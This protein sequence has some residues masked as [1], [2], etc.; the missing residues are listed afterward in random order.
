[1]YLK[2]LITGAFHFKTF[3][4]QKHMYVNSKSFKFQLKFDVK[5]IKIWRSK[6]C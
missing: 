1:M 5:V 3:I 4:T 6:L 2:F